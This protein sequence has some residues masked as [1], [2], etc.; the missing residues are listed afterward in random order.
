MFQQSN[1]NPLNPQSCLVG[2]GLTGGVQMPSTTA[3]AT[4]LDVMEAEVPAELMAQLSTLE[5]IFYAFS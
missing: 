4:I 3:T 5:Y 1:T 2:G